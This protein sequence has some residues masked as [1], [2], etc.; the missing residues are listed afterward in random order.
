MQCIVNTAY[1]SERKYMKLEAGDECFYLEGKLELINQPFHSK[2]VLQHLWFFC[3][4]AYKI[5]VYAYH[6][7]PS[8][9]ILEFPFFHKMDW[10]QQNNAAKPVQQYEYYL[11]QF[12]D[13]IQI[14]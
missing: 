11:K 10:G 1:S 5:Y 7:T 14:N 3:H 12:S 9:E 4:K 8:G 13:G 2:T 6:F